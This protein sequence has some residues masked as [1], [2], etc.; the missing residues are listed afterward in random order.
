MATVYKFTTTDDESYGGMAWGV[1][2][3]NT[4]TGDDTQDLCSDG[5]IHAYA[6][7]RLALFMNPGHGNYWPTF[8]MWSCTGTVGKTKQQTKL[9]LRELT[10]DVEVDPNPLPTYAQKIK[11]AIYATRQVYSDGVWKTWAYNY[12]SGLEP[13]A[14]TS[15]AL[16]I[17]EVMAAAR[18]AAER[19]KVLWDRARSTAKV[20]A[21][22]GPTVAAQQKAAL[23]QDALRR[24]EDAL[25]SATPNRAIVLQAQVKELL[26][27]ANAASL[28]AAATPAAT[29]AAEAAQRAET[30]AKVLSANAAAL[31]AAAATLMAAVADNT[32][33]DDL[34][35]LHASR[36]AQMAGEAAD[37]Q[38]LTIDFVALADQAYV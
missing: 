29:A 38:A 35:G 4:A 13:D 3:T 25:R 18:A 5:W 19:S 12:T 23:A 15:A 33:E 26:A 28:A 22:I 27:A 24:A 10:T 16:I 34:V 1:G 32:G 6:S 2:V 30:A 20:A 8:H 17:E 7:K 11:F 36:A 14:A 21:D 37:F 9:G 31:T